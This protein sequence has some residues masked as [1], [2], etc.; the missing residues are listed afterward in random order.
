MGIE[1]TCLEVGE[2]L[3]EGVKDKIQIC[4]IEAPR[5]LKGWD[6]AFGLIKHGLF[7]DAIYAIQGEEQPVVFA[8]GKNYI[9]EISDI[10]KEL[11]LPF[12]AMR[13]KDISVY[14][15]W[16]PHV[17]YMMGSYPFAK[18]ANAAMHKLKESH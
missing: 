3:P 8:T 17:G 11:N 10:A 4:R 1:Q 15:I 6:I 12:I 5:H 16:Q 14:G 18:Y 2:K 13:D 7:Y 9:R